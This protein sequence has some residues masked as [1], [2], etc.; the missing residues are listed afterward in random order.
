MAVGCGKPVSSYGTEDIIC[1]LHELKLGSEAAA[2]EQCFR[3]R[4]IT[5]PVLLGLNDNALYEIGVQRGWQRSRI[6]SAVIAAS[7][8]SSPSALAR[9][10]R[11][12][13]DDCDVEDTVAVQRLHNVGGHACFGS[14]ESPTKVTW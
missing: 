11:G 5:G 8:A 7:A 14:T 3:A 2:I 10:R 12:R 6:R 13:V 1:F 4:R 9:H